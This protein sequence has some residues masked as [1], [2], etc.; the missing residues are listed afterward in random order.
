MQ[1]QTIKVFIK[2]YKLR[3]NGSEREV[4]SSYNYIIMTQ[5]PQQKSKM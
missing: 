2:N 1:N 3:G 4:R 5:Q